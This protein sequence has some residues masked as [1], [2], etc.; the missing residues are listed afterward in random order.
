MMIQKMRSQNNDYT[1]TKTRRQHNI[2]QICYKFQIFTP[3]TRDYHDFAYLD[4]RSN[5]V[6]IALFFITQKKKKKQLLG[7]H[8]SCDSEEPNAPTGNWYVSKSRA[9]QSF[10]IIMMLN[11]FLEHENE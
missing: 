3:S 1:D 11:L 6:S 5:D 7:L 9:S 8:Y 10:N 4:Q 2:H